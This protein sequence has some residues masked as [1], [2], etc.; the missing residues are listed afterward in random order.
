[1]RS[2]DERM[3]QIQKRVKAIQK[4]N[5]VKKSRGL[6]TAAYLACIGLI[7]A[8]SYFLAEEAETS[9]VQAPAGSVASTFAVGRLWGYV[10]VGIVAFLLGISVTLLCRVLR[11]KKR[12]EDGK[13]G[14][15]R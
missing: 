8:S 15:G 1:M 9:L 4:Q 5:E 3:T 7:V 10:S 12:E 13:D 14:A 11:E 2:T 6:I